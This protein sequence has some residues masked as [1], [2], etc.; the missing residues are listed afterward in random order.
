MATISEQVDA[1]RLPVRDRS[2]ELLERLAQI[3]NKYSSYDFRIEGHANQEYWQNAARAAREEKEELGPL[4]LARAEAQIAALPEGAPER[5]AL[6]QRLGRVLRPKSDGRGAR[7][8]TLVSEES[9]EQD[10]A[11]HRQLF[12]TEQGYAYEI[13][14]AREVQSLPPA[15]DGA[16]ARERTA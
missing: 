2:D 10:F 7:F 5:V 1:A 12:L 13:L 9:V 4:S 16:A 3:L 14:D 8:Y 15:S 11:Q 6:A